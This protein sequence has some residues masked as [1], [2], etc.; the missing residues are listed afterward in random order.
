MSQIFSKIRV[1]NSRRSTF[2]LSHNQVTSAD[3]GQ[4][5]PICYRDMLPNDDFIVT[6]S[7]FV[8]LAPCAVPFYGQIKVRLHHFFVP[9]RILYD[10]WDAFI[11]QSPSNF[12]VPPYF[13][14]GAINQVLDEDPQFNPSA[15]PSVVRVLSP[16]TELKTSGFNPRLDINLQ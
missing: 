14:V 10:A 15:S 6:P 11:S 12:T 2:D 16:I 7:A 4:L 9:Y 13:T 8:R 3:F 1:G 5:I